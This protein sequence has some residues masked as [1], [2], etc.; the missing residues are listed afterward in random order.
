MPIATDR[1]RMLLINTFIFLI[2]FVWADE[3]IDMPRVTS[4]GQPTPINWVEALIETVVIAAVGFLTVTRFFSKQ[5][6]K[7][8]R[9]LAREERYTWITVSCSFLGLCCMVWLN[10]IIDVPYLLLQGEKTP[11]NWS[12]A[13]VETFLIIIVGGNSTL[14]SDAQD[15]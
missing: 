15:T 7:S 3:L 9:G 10:E 1:L 11:L 5:E 14:D 6:A 13:A 12:E 2:A 4:G 8:P